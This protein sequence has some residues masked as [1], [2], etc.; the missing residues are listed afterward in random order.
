MPSTSSPFPPDYLSL[1]SQ[2]E[3]LSPIPQSESKTSPLGSPQHPNCLPTKPNIYL[4]LHPSSFSCLLYSLIWGHCFHFYSGFNI[5]LFPK[6][7]YST[8][9]LF[10]LSLFTSFFPYTWLPHEP[11]AVWI[12]HTPPVPTKAGLPQQGQG[13][14]WI[15][16][17][18]PSLWGAES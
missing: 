1:M 5:F 17:K 18:S 12:C 10:T 7:P 3:P 6:E 16:S 4:H 14:S 8:P 9:G 15:K 13:P 11:G 2:L